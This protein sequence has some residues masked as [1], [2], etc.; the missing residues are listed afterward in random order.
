MLKLTL[1]TSC[2]S[3]KKVENS[4]LDQL[5]DLQ[6]DSKILLFYAPPTLLELMMSIAKKKDLP[7]DAELEVK[8]KFRDVFRDYFENMEEIDPQLEWKDKF[9]EI[10]I[11]ITRLCLKITDKRTIEKLESSGENL[12]KYLN[13]RKNQNN[14]KDIDILAFHVM[15]EGNVFVTKDSPLFLRNKKTKETLESE[16]DT[17]I[18]PLNS[19]FIKEIESFT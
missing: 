15:N 14:H 17:K 12:C 4:L 19:D 6:E 7:K 2:F 18:R 9:H 1:D 3:L 13:S 5:L 11:F 8:R 10:A 16:F